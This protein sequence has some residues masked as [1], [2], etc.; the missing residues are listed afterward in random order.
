MTAADTTTSR[1]RP[2]I[3]TVG[4]A[5]GLVAFFAMV[6]ALTWTAVVTFEGNTVFAESPSASQ[7]DQAPEGMDT[8]DASTSSAIE[9]NGIAV[10]LTRMAIGLGSD[11]AVSYLTYGYPFPFP[12]QVATVP[13]T[14][15]AE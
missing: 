14:P 13:D 3:F 8:E 5:L 10:W 7:P 6:L 2:L 4:I 15:A 11:S 12:D 1:L 9:S